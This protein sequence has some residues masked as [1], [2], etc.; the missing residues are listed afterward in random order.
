MRLAALLGAIREAKGPV[1]GIDLA[2]RLGV[3]PATVAEMLVA[4]RASGQLAPE[5]RTEPAPEICSSSGACSMSCPG[6][7]EC[8][9]VIDLSVTGLEIRPASGV[10]R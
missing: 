10:G 2:Q 8:S 3:A 5:T 9:L 4:L 7:G 6:P 1:T